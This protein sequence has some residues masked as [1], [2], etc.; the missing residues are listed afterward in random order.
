MAQKTAS[1]IIP[2]YNVEKYLPR[3]LDSL[4]AQTL[5]NLE[6]ICI[7]DGSPDRCIDILRD[8]EA[9]N[10]DTIV[11]IDK[12]NEGVWRG[13]LDAIAI[14]RG[15]Y[16]GFVDS[17]DYVE[18]NFAEMLYTT[19]K[20]NDAD[21]SV[22]GFHRVDVGTGKILSTEMTEERPPFYVEQ[23]PQ[24]LLELNGAP[25]NKFFKAEILKNIHDFEVPPRIFDDMMLHLLTYPMVKKVAFTPHALV[26][27]IIR[28]DSIMTTIDK[29]K[30]ESTYNAMLEV[31]Q[32]YLKE[33]SGKLLYF[34][35]AAA[36]LHLGLSLM[37]RI[38][39]DKTA[40]L[41]DELRYNRVY[42]DKNFPTWNTDQ[43]ISARNARKYKGALRKTYYGRI[44]YNSGL[45]ATAL[46]AYRAMISAGHDI[47]W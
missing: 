2:C 37:F 6:I 32:V 34:L 26:N 39:Y 10:P 15:E 8:Y 25:W 13:R 40:D 31:K 38:S 11:V 29:S 28:N 19:A 12:E 45:M 35:D 41:K 16:I 27:Y 1:I 18:P 9:K 46:Q 5:E 4:L 44:I 43:I 47:K 42:L 24:R 7:N 3:C 20:E 36:F 21:I 14:A 22:G 33:A 30:I 17:D 23:E